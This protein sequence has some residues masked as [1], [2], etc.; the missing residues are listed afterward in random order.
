MSPTILKCE[1]LN[2]FLRSLGDSFGYGL[3]YQKAVVEIVI[4]KSFLMGSSAI[5]HSV[6]FYRDKRLAFYILPLLE[7]DLIHSYALKKHLTDNHMDITP[8]VSEHTIFNYH[9]WSSCLKGRQCP[10][11]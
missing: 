2:L 9:F 7:G 5:L 8:M 10:P 3:K 6:W 11:L 4:Q 1:S